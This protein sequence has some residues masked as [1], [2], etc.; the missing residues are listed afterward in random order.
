MPNRVLFSTS[1][2]ALFALPLSAPVHADEC[3]IDEN[4]EVVLETLDY[5][6]RWQW[7]ANA[8]IGLDGRMDAASARQYNATAT[9][10]AGLSYDGKTCRWVGLDGEL[11]GYH[12]GEALGITGRQT[13]TFCLPYPVF[14]PEMRVTLDQDLR[15]R[16]SAAP[17]VRA[18][19]VRGGN[20]YMDV[21]TIHLSA[22]QDEVVQ[23]VWLL[24]IGAGVGFVTQDVADEPTR[25]NEITFLMDVIRGIERGGGFLGQDGE[26]RILRVRG[27]IRTEALEDGTGGRFNASVIDI[28]F[29][30]MFSGRIPRTALFYD[31]S[32]GM[33][34][35]QLT[36]TQMQLDGPQVISPLVSLHLLG[37]S[38]EQAYGVGYAR[39]VLP[40]N[41]AALLLEDRLAGWWRRGSDDSATT[42]RGFAA[43]TQLIESDGRR[44][45]TLTGGVGLDH[46]MVMGKH[47]RIALGAE[48][49]RS[50]YAELHG[51]APLEA[52]WVA[53]VS[54]SATA[55]AGSR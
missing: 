9:V 35:G 34:V 22:T 40:T 44:S 13:L 38:K 11:G 21:S 15:P 26:L 50:Y 31:L 5:S 33:T 43:L 47:A 12:D 28:A 42:V 37:G 20:I 52:S 49:A 25:T 54:V 45:H 17:T 16:L 8:S 27:D 41:Y 53:Q 7:Q 24:A 23:E 36:D 39:G 10:G 55:A 6:G 18:S 51:D 3:R 19:R 4:C 46:E 14:R 29:F 1:L 30:E 48:V 32:L 2:A